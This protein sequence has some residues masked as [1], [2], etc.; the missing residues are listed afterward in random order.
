[1]TR[2]REPADAAVPLWS[3]AVILR[4]FTFAFAVSAVI[5]NQDDY[6]RPKLAWT[7]LAAMAGWTVL[8]MFA[9]LHKAGRN[10]LIVGADVVVTCGLMYTSVF[11]LSPSQLSATAP[12]ITT[13]WASGPPVAAAV[14][15][16]RAAGVAAGLV[17]AV[18]TAVA[19]GEVNTDVLRDAVLL[20]G[21]GFVIGLASVTA[22][23]SQERMARALRAEAATAERERLARS[24][25]DSVLQ[26]LARV[27]RRGAELGGDAAELASLAGEQE[28]ALRSLVDAAPPESTPDDTADL[29]SRLQLLNSGKVQVSTPATPVMLPTDHVAE[30]ASAVREA[31]L[32]VDR[33]AGDGARAWVLVEDLGEAVVITV[34]DD[35]VGMTLDRIDQAAVEGRMGIAKSIRGR[36]DA[37][38]GTLQLETA[39]SEGTE[40]EIRIP[41]RRANGRRDTSGGAWWRKWPFQ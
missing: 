16:G 27:R 4:L 40:W 9:Y 26:V 1:V 15:R 6:L 36:V 35:G 3:G 32:N 34:R 28:V 11:I 8:T 2:R 7:V 13:V 5:L 22:Q 10:A 37:I 19:R 25:H 21:C 12:L 41:R 24:I 23:R 30:M 14:L 38:G 29:C 31:L 20:I 33:H 39:P 17:V 18:A